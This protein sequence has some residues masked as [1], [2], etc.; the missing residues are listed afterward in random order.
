[1][2][3]A[4]VMINK[5]RQSVCN[6]HDFLDLEKK[7]LVTVIPNSIYFTAILVTPRPAAIQR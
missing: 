4:N 7:Y 1:M 6:E 2:N 5:I 3:V